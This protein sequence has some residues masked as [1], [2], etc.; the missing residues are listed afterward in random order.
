MSPDDEAYYAEP[1]SLGSFD[2]EYRYELAPVVYISQVDGMAL[3]AALARRSG[4]RGHVVNDVQTTLA[5]KGGRGY[6]VV[7]TQ[8]GTKKGAG[9]IV[10]GAHHDAYFH[11]GL[12]DTGGVTSGMLMAKAIKMSHYRPPASITF[13]FTTGEEYGRVNSYYDWLIGA[14]HA[15]TKRHTQ[16]AG[17]TRPHD[18]PRVDG[19]EGRDHGDARHARGQD[20]RSRRRSRRCPPAPCPTATT[21]RR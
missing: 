4:A 1:T 18:E 2:A 6:N 17:S 12:D 16:W 7:A 15:I 11:A 9:R 13:L 8:A 19:H 5:R 10:I 3:K 21:S 14:W 20:A